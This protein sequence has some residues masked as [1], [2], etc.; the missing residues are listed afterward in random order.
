MGRIARQPAVATFSNR[1]HV[2]CSAT[3]SG[4]ILFF[5]LPT[6]DAAQAARFVSVATSALVAGRTLKIQYDPA[7][8]SGAGFGCATSD[9]RRAMALEMF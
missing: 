2:R 7:D 3:V 4:G 8:L 1:V 6:T 9:C 5:A